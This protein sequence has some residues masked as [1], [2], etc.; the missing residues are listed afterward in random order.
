MSVRKR[1]WTTRKGENKTAWVVDYS[2]P[3]GGRHLKTFERK[4]DADAFA[5][6]V[7]V[8]VRAGTHRP[9]S[10]SITVEKAA[11]NWIKAVELEGREAS[12][13]AQ[14]RQHAHHINERIGKI[15]L[16]ALTAMRVNQLR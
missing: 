11:A 4:K 12:T 3:E 1:T 9:L 5:K 16:G 7:G 13:L 14:Y 2:M 10:R 15:K 6:Q 8:A